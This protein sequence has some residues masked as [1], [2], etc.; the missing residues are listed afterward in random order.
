MDRNVIR[1]INR[2]LFVFVQWHAGFEFAPEN[3]HL[4]GSAGPKPEQH[5]QVWMLSS[6]TTQK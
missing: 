6:P 4:I 2:S 5:L 1:S 3:H